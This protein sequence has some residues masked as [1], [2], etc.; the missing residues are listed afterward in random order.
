MRCTTV[1]CGTAADCELLRTGLWGRSHQKEARR[2]PQPVLQCLLHLPR[3]HD[4]LRGHQLPSPHSMQPASTCTGLWPCDTAVRT[5]NPTPVVL[6]F[7]RPKVPGQAVPREE[8]AP[9]PE[10]R[11]RTA[12][13]PGPRSAQCI[14]RRRSGRRQRRRRHRRCSTPCSDPSASHELPRI[15]GNSGPSPC[16]CLRLS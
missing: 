13:L 11:Q 9:A 5:A 15:R 8:E 4:P 10:E 3:L 14:R 1:D 12:E 7:R 16:Q 2:P 6:H